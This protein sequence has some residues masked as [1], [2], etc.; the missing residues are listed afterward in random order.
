MTRTSI[1]VDKAGYV[2]ISYDDEFAG[3]VER[4]FFCPV[5]GGYVRESDK[6]HRYPQVCEK[7]GSMGSTLVASSREALPALI[8]REYRAMRRAEARRIAGIDAR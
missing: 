7:L 6:A 8:R 3:R 1:T 2:T 4:T 5:D